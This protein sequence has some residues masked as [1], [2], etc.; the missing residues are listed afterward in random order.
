M[1]KIKYDCPESDDAM[2]KTDCGFY[3][4]SCSQE[5][6]DFRE[7]S[8]EEIALIKAENP[9][10]SCGMFTAEQAVVD[11]RAQ[12]HNVFKMAFAA[13]FLLGFNVT[14]LFGQ[15]HNLESNLIVTTTEVTS[16]SIFISGTLKNEKG[17][18]I[19]GSVT[20]Y[21]GSE[22]MEIETDDEGN[23]KV[24]LPREAIGVKVELI[25]A[26]HGYL[27]KSITIEPKASKCYT[28]QIEL[29]KYKRPLLRR[30]RMI[31]GR[32]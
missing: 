2:S 20:C 16:S 4:S 15:S 28:Y 31:R 29:K 3:C 1:I 21:Y 13:I 26:S 23:F 11:N 24:E 32:F 5:V 30:N 6:F 7:K 9:S 22:S 18:Q 27:L 19:E 8:S 10:V 17:D 25:F 12:V 14:M